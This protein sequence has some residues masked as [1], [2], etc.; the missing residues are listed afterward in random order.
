M[1][2]MIAKS[3][4]LSIMIFLLSLSNTVYAQLNTV[5]KS[6][7]D[8]ILVNRLDTTGVV[9]IHGKHFIPASLLANNELTPAL[10]SL[11]ANDVSSFPLS[12]TSVGVTFDFSTGLPVS[13]TESMGPIFAETGRTLGKGKLNVG[14]NYTYL[15]LSSFRGLP[16]EDMRFTFT[17]QDVTPGT[18][19]LGTSPNESDLIDV[20]MGMKVRAS[21]FALFA[22]FGVL[23]NLDVGVAVP[24]I[25]VSVKG[26]AV[27]TIES[28]TYGRLGIANHHFIKDGLGTTG[29]DPYNP[30][31]QTYVPYD[32]SATGVGDIALRAKYSFVRNPDFDVAALV[33]VRLATGKKEDFLGSGKTNFRVSGILSRKIADFTPHINVAYEK[34]SADFES[35]QFVFAAGFDNKVLSG[36]TFAFAVL[37]DISLDNNKTIKLFPGTVL[38][39]DLPPPGTAPA[40]SKSIRNVPLSNIPDRSND[41][42]T[43]ASFGFRYA[44][45]ERLIFLGNILVPL[46]DGGLRASVAPT[47]GVSLSL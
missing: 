3:L 19:T 1:S 5:F 40:G 2:K 21:I 16:T 46:N 10:N 4:L 22:T 14:V 38:I 12:S 18:D 17:H 25:N 28:Y 30:I 24:V 35:D 7:F 43:S 15:D 23:N 36:L 13:I 45:S 31:L 9:G 47:V 27:A 26:T 39:E 20:V 42:T 11:V 37:G 32:Q 29:T 6:I 44:P 41:N 8:E 33:D 34:R